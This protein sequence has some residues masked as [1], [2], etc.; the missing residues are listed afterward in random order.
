M[1]IIPYSTLKACSNL[2]CQTASFVNRN[3]KLII[4][5]LIAAAILKKLWP[6]SKDGGSRGATSRRSPVVRANS[7]SRSVGGAIFPVGAGTTYFQQA[8]GFN[9]FLRETG[10]SYESQLEEARRR[11]LL[12]QQGDG[13]SYPQ[14]YDELGGSGD[15]E[16][17][18]ARRRSLADAEQNRVKI[19]EVRAQQDEEYE[20]ALREDQR[21]MAEQ[22]AKE[23]AEL[24]RVQAE[25]AEALA[26]EPEVFYHEMSAL[27][28][29]IGF[30]SASENL[31][32]SFRSPLGDE[33]ARTYRGTFQGIIKDEVVITFDRKT[34][35]VNIYHSSR[36]K[37]L[38]RKIGNT[39]LHR[40]GTLTTYRRLIEAIQESKQESR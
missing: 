9:S 11:S 19:A 24:L 27:P 25:Q 28:L 38:E 34:N 36:D 3:K 21:R 5:T 33:E 16:F 13:S 14:L 37:P 23:E 20:V 10:G 12:D 29:D 8:A 39:L 1:R 30:V 7:D 40:E 22:K 26:R 4:I 17:E 6:S 15:L 18:E 31:V 35:S 32:E 2:I